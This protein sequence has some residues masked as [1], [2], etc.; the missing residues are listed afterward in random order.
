[1]AVKL[2]RK[3]A[4]HQLQATNTEQEV[5]MQ[6]QAYSKLIIDVVNSGAIRV[7]INGVPETFDGQNGYLVSYEKPLIIYN[8][9]VNSI[10]FIRDFDMT[11]NVD[12]Q[13]LGLYY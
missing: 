10:K 3:D 8:H 9:V 4:F 1:M 2:S 5:N 7:Q 13:V 11:F 12:F 6:N